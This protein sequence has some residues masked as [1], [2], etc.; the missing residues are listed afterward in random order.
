MNLQTFLD[1]KKNGVSFKI[2]NR[3][4]STISKLELTIYYKDLAGDVIYDTRITPI[5]AESLF[6]MTEPLKPNYIWQQEGQF[7]ETPN[8]PSEWSGDAD[9]EITEI[10]FE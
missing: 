7:F 4:D 3:G 5:N 2:K 9:V 10:Q 8:V 1:R 6:G